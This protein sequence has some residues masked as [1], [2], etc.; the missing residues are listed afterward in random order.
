M[1]ADDAGSGTPD[2]L[3]TLIRKAR[4]SDSSTPCVSD[5][6]RRWFGSRKE[7]SM[8]SHLLSSEY[9]LSAYRVPVAS[10]AWLDTYTVRPSSSSRSMVML[11]D[12]RLVLRLPE[13]SPKLRR[14]Y[15]SS[16]PA[17]QGST[18]RTCPLISTTYSCRESYTPALF[19]SERNTGLTYG[20]NRHGE[21]E[22]TPYLLGIQ[23]TNKLQ[24]M[25]SLR[26]LEDLAYP[27]RYLTSTA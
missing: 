14:E 1:N 20:L 21:M 4:Q 27:V 26:I 10:D 23:M 19:R 5:P 18:T 16:I 17:F 6:M 2:N 7:S 22:A 11:L 8:L 3:S 15:L 24:M 25:A 12:G 13:S 9:L